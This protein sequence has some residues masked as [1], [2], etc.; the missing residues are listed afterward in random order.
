[1]SQRFRFLRDKLKNFR[2]YYVFHIKS[3][4]IFL[5]FGLVDYY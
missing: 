1:M 2:G 5:A 4:D 3:T